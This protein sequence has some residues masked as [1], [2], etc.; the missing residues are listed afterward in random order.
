M[1]AFR[2]DKEICWLDICCE[3]S[4]N[5]RNQRKAATQT[6][7]REYVRLESKDGIVSKSWRRSGER[8]R[9]KESSPRYGVA[10]LLSHPTVELC[11]DGGSS[12]CGHG[13]GG[14]SWA[15]QA[16]KAL[17][18]EVRSGQFCSSTRIWSMQSGLVVWWCK[19]SN[20]GVPAGPGCSSC[21][22]P[23]RKCLHMW[24]LM[25]EVKADGLDDCRRKW[26]TGPVWSTSQGL[27]SPSQAPDW[28]A[29]NCVGLTSHTAGVKSFHTSMFLPFQTQ[30]A[31]RT[32]KSSDNGI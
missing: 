25:H 10:R 29:L 17:R 32:S 31:S 4:E 21:R 8:R 26:S 20:V 24:Y 1:T 27:T 14:V 9:K 19:C 15:E 16:P 13:H 2:A 3:V 6:K 22:P 18:G 11:G 30:Q 7:G 28:T 5:E 23:V 12:L